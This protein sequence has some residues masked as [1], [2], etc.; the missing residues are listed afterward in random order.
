MKTP[1]IFPRM[2]ILIVEDMPTIRQRM[3]SILY[4]IGFV[5]IDEAECG[6]EALTLLQQENACDYPY[7]LVISDIKMPKMDGLTFLRKVKDNPLLRQTKVFIVTTVSETDFILDAISLG[8]SN[9]LLKPFDY[10]SIRR[11]LFQIFYPEIKEINK[12]V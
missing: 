2:K 4:E 5:N 8:A 10:G 7:D 9:Y 6:E 1:A 3:K 11:K 12:V